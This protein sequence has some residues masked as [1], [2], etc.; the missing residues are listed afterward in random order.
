MG[1]TVYAQAYGRP[2]ATFF[3]ATLIA[4]TGLLSLAGTASAQDDE[5]ARMHFQAGASHYDAGEYED[6]IKQFERA[7]ELSQRPALFYNLALSYQAM[8]NLEKAVDYL[9]RYLAQVQEIPNRRALE[10]RLENLQSRLGE[11]QE[12]ERARQERLAAAQQQAE[13]SEGETPTDDTPTTPTEEPAADEVPEVEY[14]APASSDRIMPMAS[15][16][17]FGVAAAGVVGTTAFGIMAI[18][19]Q[20]SIED[21]CG[22][23]AQCSDSQVANL[24]TYALLSDVCT[25][26]AIASAAL[27]MV[28]ILTD[29]GG[30]NDQMA[31][32]ELSPFFTDRAAGAV[33]SGAF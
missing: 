28:F 23:N 1:G 8:G 21:G 27:G 4:L 24:K 2:W 12:R 16:V 17:S 6:A 9:E 11:Q 25:G 18:G 7:F 20:G 19:E 13:A 33:L 15:W 26:V 31:S 32:F 22:A 3:A 14:E 5:R 10:R 30:A 29:D